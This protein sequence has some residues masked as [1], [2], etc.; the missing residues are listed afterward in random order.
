[1]LGTNVANLMDMKQKGRDNYH[2]KE[3]RRREIDNHNCKL[4]NA[5]VAQIRKTYIPRKIKQTDLAIE[6]GVTQSLI[7]SI[8]RMETRKNG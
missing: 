6:Y 4:D 3:N 7:S 5:Q 2:H 1:M 8:I